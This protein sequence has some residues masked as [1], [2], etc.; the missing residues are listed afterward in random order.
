[1]LDYCIFLPKC[2]R[3]QASEATPQALRLEN[4]EEAVQ[5]STVQTTFIIA[6]K[7]AET[8]IYNPFFIFLS[9]CLSNN[10]STYL[11]IYRYVCISIYLYVYTSIF[12]SIYLYVY[13][14]PIY[15]YVHIYI[16]L[17]IYIHLSIC[18]SI[19]LSIYLSSQLYFIYPFIFYLS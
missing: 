7:V 11:P 13:P 8:A 9:I 5:W 4:A 6:L 12:M 17:Y 18:I 3:Q 14:I 1:M 16:Y 15:L 19:Y 2:L 10:L